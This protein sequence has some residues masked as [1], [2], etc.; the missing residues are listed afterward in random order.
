MC[1]L[2]CEEDQR[3]PGLRLRQPARRSVCLWAVETQPLPLPIPGKG[4]AAPHLGGVQRD[5]GAY[6][7]SCSFQ[8]G[9]DAV[10]RAGLAGTAIAV[11]WVVV[12]WCPG[13]TGGVSTACLSGNRVGGLSPRALC[14]CR[15]QCGGGSGAVLLAGSPTGLERGAWGMPAQ[16]TALPRALWGMEGGQAWA[17]L[18]LAQTSGLLCASHL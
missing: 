7:P 1:A 3:Y 18:S 10:G 8:Q 9:W 12:C 4:A 15:R 17:Q 5:L 13:K 6:R 11:G 16:D 14:G 2:D